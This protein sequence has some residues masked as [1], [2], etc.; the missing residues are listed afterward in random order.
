VGEK[1][2]GE[3]AEGRGGIVRGLGQ[4]D[5]RGVGSG[6]P[7]GNEITKAGEKMRMDQGMEWEW[8]EEREGG[9][10]WRAEGR[11]KEWRGGGG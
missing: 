4:R 8:G 11:E 10:E 7:R 9:G 3:E 6:K 1:E 5:E 2:G